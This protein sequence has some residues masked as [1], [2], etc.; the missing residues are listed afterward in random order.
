MSEK[1]KGR[2]SVVWAYQRIGCPI[3]WEY[4]V[5]LCTTGETMFHDW[6]SKG[7]RLGDLLSFARVRPLGDASTQGRLAL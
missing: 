7:A 2:H 5:A 1:T 4:A 3:A 6:R